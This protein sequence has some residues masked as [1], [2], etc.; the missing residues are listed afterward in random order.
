MPIGMS[1]LRILRL[2]RRGGH[3]VE[4]DVGEEDDA[5][6]AQDAA[7]A[8]VAE[9]A[10]VR[11]ERTGCQLAVFTY[12]KP[13]P[14][15]RNTIAILMNTMTLLNRAD[16]LMPMTSKRSSA[17]MSTIA[18]HVDHAAGVTRARCVRALS[19][20]ESARIHASRRGSIERRRASAARNAAK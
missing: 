14:I 18:G 1:R 4:A 17:A 6:A 3:G 2:L 19:H 13:K 16:S 5:G 9:L 10:G 11:R 15:T 20:R 8:V 12:M 7:P